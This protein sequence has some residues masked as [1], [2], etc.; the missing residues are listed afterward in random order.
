MEGELAGLPDEPN[1]MEGGE[2]F[3]HVVHQCVFGWF[4]QF[5]HRSVLENTDPLF[6]GSSDPLSFD[7]RCAGGA[8]R[9]Q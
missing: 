3:L 4:H 7:S 8:A 9:G 5:W 1:L 2:S 6:H